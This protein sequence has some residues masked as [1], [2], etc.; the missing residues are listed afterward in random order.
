MTTATTGRLFIL[1]AG[2]AGILAT[3]GCVDKGARGAAIGSGPAK[4]RIVTGDS[5][6]WGSVP[7]ISL[8]DTVVIMNVGGDTLRISNVKP[9][10]GCTTA[11]IDRNTLGPGDTARVIVTMDTEGKSGSVHKSLTISSNDS[12]TPNKVIPLMATI[13]RDVVAEPTLFPVVST[14]KT[15]DE[16]T[17]SIVVKNMGQ[18][19]LSVGPPRFA[20]PPPMVAEFDMKGPVQLAP[21]DSTTISATVRTIQNTTAVGTV[22]IP[23]SSKLIPELKLTMTA[24]I[25]PNM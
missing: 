6:Q 23:T 7:P 4:I 21:G 10:C 17:T 16:G 5:V 2:I 13:L 19:P 20:T 1:V 8:V 24:Q 18:T 11:P 12:T 9:S 22:V 15:G 14:R 25:N 3:S